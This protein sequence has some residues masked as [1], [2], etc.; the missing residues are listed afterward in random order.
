MPT[1][2]QYTHLN[3]DMQNTILQA[4]AYWQETGWA[5]DLVHNK[6]AELEKKIDRIAEAVTCSHSKAL[7]CPRC[8]NRSI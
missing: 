3:D 8:S 7:V 6:L 2:D 4:R 5:E 1:P